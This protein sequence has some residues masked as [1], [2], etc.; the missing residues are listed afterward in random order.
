[1]LNILALS[2]KQ[3][4]LVLALAELQTKLKLKIIGN[5][6]FKPGRIVEFVKPFEYGEAG[7]DLNRLA[8]KLTKEERD[9]FEDKLNRVFAVDAYAGNWNDDIYDGSILDLA[10]NDQSFKVVLQFCK[11]KIFF[12]YKLINEEKMMQK[13]LLRYI[14]DRREA[15]DFRN[16]MNIKIMKMCGILFKDVDPRKRP[17]SRALQINQ[18]E[19]IIYPTSER[20]FVCSFKNKLIDYLCLFFVK[21]LQ[22][23][24]HL[25]KNY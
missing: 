20:F 1:M 23:N 3:M 17:T 21:I 2:S 16:L 12:A 24:C 8:H 7:F 22:W 5:Q 10:S 4:Q 14:E 19:D 6:C 9:E 15:N 11:E 13:D 18:R 25:F